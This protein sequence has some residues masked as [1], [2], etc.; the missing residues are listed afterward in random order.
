MRRR[1]NEPSD[2]RAS[3]PGSEKPVLVSIDSAPPSVLSPK[4][5]FDPG[6]RFSEE[7]AA[8]GMRSQFTVSPN[9]ALSR[10]PSR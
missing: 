6:I 4:M 1:P 10:A 5:G 7:M 8:V 2:S 9:G 3:A